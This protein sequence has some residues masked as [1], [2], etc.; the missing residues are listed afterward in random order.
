MP[1]TI[2]GSSFLSFFLSPFLSP[3]LSL[4][5]SFLRAYLWNFRHLQLALTSPVQLISF[6]YIWLAG[7]CLKSQGPTVS[8]RCLWHCSAFQLIIYMRGEFPF[9]F[10][11][12][13]VALIL[14]SISVISF[15]SQSRK[16]T[17]RLE[18]EI[19]GIIEL[20]AEVCSLLYACH[21]SRPS[22]CYGQVAKCLPK[23][24]E[25]KRCVPLPGLYLKTRVC[26][27]LVLSPLPTHWSPIRSWLHLD[28]ADNIKAEE[29]EEQDG[30]NLDP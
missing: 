21:F 13:P 15:Y 6:Y 10:L 22:W 28:P 25:Q 24:C 7:N 18:M 14:R 8:V 16:V 27:L 23:K 30:R 26:L 3:F 19:W 29:M 1:G 9:V 11:I 20:T 12:F 5:L 17:W 2:V 4:Y